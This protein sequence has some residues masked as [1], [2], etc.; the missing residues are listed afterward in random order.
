MYSIIS[1]HLLPLANVFPWKHHVLRH[2]VWLH[3]YSDQVYKPGVAKVICSRAQNGAWQLHSLLSLSKFCTLANMLGYSPRI[4]YPSYLLL[5]RELEVQ[6]ESLNALYC[7]V[8]HL[9]K[10]EYLCKVTVVDITW[11]SCSSVPIC[12]SIILVNLNLKPK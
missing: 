8:K 1:A 2:L 3:L 4:F 7:N 5:A 6:K 9:R 10:T 12:Y 11:L